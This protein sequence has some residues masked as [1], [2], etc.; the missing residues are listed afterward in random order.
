MFGLQFRREAGQSWFHMKSPEEPVMRSPIIAAVSIAVL[1]ACG[2]RSETPDANAAEVAAVAEAVAAVEAVSAA[3]FVAGAAC[4]AFIPRGPLPSGMTGFSIEGG[5]IGEV[6]GEAIVGL[7]L[8]D[9]SGAAVYTFGAGADQL[10][11]FEAVTTPEELTDALTTWV[12]EPGATRWTSTGE[13][14]VWAEGEDLPLLGDFYFYPEEGFDRTAYEALRAEA[15][16]MYCHVV[17]RES[18][19][20]L[21]LSI[22]FPGRIGVHSLPG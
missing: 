12:G 8:R 3:P 5:A 16:P 9:T 13:L 1:A 22:D 7:I 4:T 6:C 14:P 2:P 10:L 11:G 21:D 18:L 20:C 15:R 19:L 17:G